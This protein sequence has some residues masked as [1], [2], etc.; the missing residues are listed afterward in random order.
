MQFRRLPRTDIDMSVVAYGPFR[1]AAGAGHGPAEG[2]RALHAAIDGGVNAIHSSAR[3][4]SYPLLVEALARH[5]KRRELNHIVK[6]VSP[7]HDESAFDAESFRRQV[8]EALTALGVDRLA[9]VQHLH[10]GPAAESVIYDSG[11]DEGRVPLADSVSEGVLEVTDQ[12]KSEGKIGTIASFPHTLSYAERI[13]PAGFDGL[14]HSFGLLEPEVLDLLDDLQARDM[15]FIGIRPLLQGLVT[16]HGVARDVLAPKHD[17]RDSRWDPW[18]DQLD[19]LRQK[20]GNDPENWTRFAIR[21]SITRET[22]TTNVIGMDTVEH[23]EVA[24]AAVDD[25]PLP[26]SVVAAAREAAARVGPIPKS[27]LDAPH[28]WTTRTVA[29]AVLRRVRRAGSS[30]AGR[31]RAHSAH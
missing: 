10:R 12:L 5:P 30:I 22:V 13:L 7:D 18:Y 4:G 23:V 3:Y 14:V 6:V 15:A 17:F 21:F 11:G 19:L 29:A 31:Q 16:D 2:V 28:V 24:L 1:F 20:L 25:G 27:T 9:V 8:D 26:A